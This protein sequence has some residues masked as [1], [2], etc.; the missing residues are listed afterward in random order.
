[1]YLYL[2]SQW[3]IMVTPQSKQNVNVNFKKDAFVLAAVAAAP[4]N[5]IAAHY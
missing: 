4:S 1:M 5:E 2:Y 3:K